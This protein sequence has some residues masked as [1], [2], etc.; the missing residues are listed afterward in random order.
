M[1]MKWHDVSIPF[2]VGMTVWPNDPPFGFSA[3]MQIAEG[4]GCNTSVAL[5]STH[6]GTHVDAPWHFEE[7]GKR[8]HELDASVFF[9]EA[10]LVDLPA[11]DIIQAKDLG[12]DP[13]PPRI[14]FKT[15]NSAIPVDAPFQPNYVGLDVDAAQ[16]LVD[17]GVRLVG[18]DYL[19]VA[20]YKQ[21]GQET[22]HRLLAHDVLVIEGLRLHG[23][24]GGV[25]TF[26]ALPL[27]LVG[28]DGAPC[29]AFL[30]LETRERER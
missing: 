2:R 21:P 6:A 29:R 18:I 4:D 23:F 27:P 12:T 7:S 30:G 20:P 19:S 3:R 16:R 1:T 5:L 15:R 24:P 13:L 9:G 17:E 26:V 25:Y 22:H 28:S 8:L 14:L 10:L 11:V